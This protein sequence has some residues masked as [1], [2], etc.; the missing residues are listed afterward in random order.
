MGL[1]TSVMEWWKWDNFR[2]S[3]DSVVRKMWLNFQCDK[4]I[5]KKLPPWTCFNCARNDSELNKKLVLM[6][7]ESKGKRKR[8]MNQKMLIKNYI[9][10]MKRENSLRCFKIFFSLPWTFIYT[11]NSGKC[12]WKWTA[13][14][15]CQAAAKTKNTREKFYH[16]RRLDVDGEN[17]NMFALFFN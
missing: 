13:E 8:I 14:N 17:K 2:S 4:Q 1:K 5:R 10:L 12:V 16:N 15:S 9:N 6:G 3:K 7:S 11:S